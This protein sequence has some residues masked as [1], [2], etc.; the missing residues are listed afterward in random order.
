MP[1]E[2][3]CQ[4]NSAVLACVRQRLFQ[5][6]LMTQVHP[7]E[8]TDPDAYFASA[9][10]QIGCAMDQLHGY[11]MLES[12]KNGITLW[13]RSFGPSSSTLSKGN[14]SLTSNWPDA[15]R[16][17]AERCAPQPTFCPRS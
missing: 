3:D 12:F 13:P 16:R 17:N 8:H 7:V 11:S 1:I 4:R 9:G 10:I 15:V 2:R 5:H 6:L 14:A